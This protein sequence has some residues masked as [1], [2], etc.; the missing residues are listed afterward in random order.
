MTNRSRS[1]E[2][3]NED[4]TMS[5]KNDLR[6]LLYV[7]LDTAKLTDKEI[8]YLTECAKKIMETKT[9]RNEA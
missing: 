9:K 8:E 1:K 3:K 6:N 2:K 7:K 5:N 4:E